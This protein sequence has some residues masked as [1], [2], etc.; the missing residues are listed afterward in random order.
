MKDL[1]ISIDEA[2]KWVVDILCMHGTKTSSARS[3]ARA[4][5][6]AEVDGHRGHGLSRV[7][8]YA[9][10]VASGKVNGGVDPKV[11]DQKKGAFR[12]DAAEG[13]AYPACD[14]AISRLTETVTD[15]GLSAATIFRSHH[16]GQAGYHAERL[17]DQGL[18]ALVLSNSP[19]AIAPW[20]GSQG[21]FGTN[22]IAFAAPRSD[23]EP[24]LIDLSLSKG[25]RGKIVLAQQ[26]GEEIPEGWALDKQGHPTS[27]PS[28]AIEGTLLPIG[29]AKGAALVLMVEIMAAGLS[30]SH[31]G[32]EAS[33]FFAA[34][35]PPPAIG[36]LVIAFDPD[37]FSGGLFSSRLELLISTMLAQDN[38]RLP[39]SMRQKKRQ[40][41]L[42]K[43]LTIPV[44]LRDELYRLMQQ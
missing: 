20:G 35:G 41:A 22:P 9:A 21:V 15:T 36:H 23:A 16:F 19:K 2:E 18:V 28:S 37:F 43:G 24:L 40:Q 11:L 14:L 32:F 33:S 38:V 4:L 29:D 1:A 27:D 42:E 7:S 5:V 39:G 26:A 12:I 31:F 34:D 13:F 30:G 8:F 44:S 3:V 10:Q 25:A 6:A 17:A